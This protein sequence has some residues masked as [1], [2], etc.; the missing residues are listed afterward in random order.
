MTRAGG[1]VRRGVVRS[2]DA[3]AGYGT[4]VETPDPA[5][6][7]GGEPGEWFFHCTAIADGTRTIDEGAAVAF[8]LAYGH[9]GRREGRD[10]RRL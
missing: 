9:R 8:T 2:F 5:T 4:V 3:A 6:G 7:A 10:L 1:P